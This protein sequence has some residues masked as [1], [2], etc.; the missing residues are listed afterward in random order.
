MPYDPTRYGQV[1]LKFGMI[2]QIGLE[3][4]SEIEIMQTLGA[5]IHDILDDLMNT[6]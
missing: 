4:T 5:E 3:A 6:E 1:M 2:K